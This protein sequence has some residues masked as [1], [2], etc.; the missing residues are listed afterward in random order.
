M[1][2]V[3]QIWSSGQRDTESQLSFL[4]DGSVVCTFANYFCHTD[5]TRIYLSGNTFLFEKY[6]VKTLLS[7]TTWSLINC[8]IEDFPQPKS[9]RTFKVN[10]L[11]SFHSSPVLKQMSRDGLKDS[12][13]R[14]CLNFQNSIAAKSQRIFSTTTLKSELLFFRQKSATVH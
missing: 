3:F 2:K 4:Q 9:F 5:R 12:T 7:S 8:S 1:S 11:C 14:I 10:R 13:V 6:L